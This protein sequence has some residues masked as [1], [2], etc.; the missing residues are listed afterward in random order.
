[1][2]TAVTN[3]L[4]I[5]P[6][7]IAKYFLYRSLVDGDLVSPIKMQ[8]LVYY[9]YA[10]ILVKNKAKLFNENIEAWPNG[11]VV[12][13]LYRELKRYGSQPINEDFLG[14]VSEND[15]MKK[16]PEEVLETLDEVYQKYMTKT[17]FELVVLTHNER[18]WVEAR[19]GLPAS[20]SSN[21]P[22]SDETILK[23]FAPDSI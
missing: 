7:D 18:P 19:K 10:W 14:R 22:I 16:F 13:S 21:N 8:K 9:A 15:L 3:K 4:N 11:P 2:S 23:T 1:M 17:P 5:P 12:P 6:S 20:E